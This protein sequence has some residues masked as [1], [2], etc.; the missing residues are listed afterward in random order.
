[1]HSKLLV[2]VNWIILSEFICTFANN[3]NDVFYGNY[4]YFLFMAV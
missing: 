3:F 4:S 2:L 1:M